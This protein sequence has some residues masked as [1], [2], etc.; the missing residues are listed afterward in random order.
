MIISA[1]WEQET[2][3]VLLTKHVDKDKRSL[4]GQSFINKH[5]KNLFKT[6]KES[7]NSSCH[8]LQ[9]PPVLPSKLTR[10]HIMIFIT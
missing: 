2:A 10:C 3:A 8:L 4:N 5:R 7:A 1:N 9:P 6:Q